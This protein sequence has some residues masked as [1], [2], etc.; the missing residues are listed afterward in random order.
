MIEV[1]AVSFS[2]D[3]KKVLE[4]IHISFEKNG[5]YGLLGPNGVGKSTLLKLLGNMLRPDEGGIFFDGKNIKDIPKKKLAQQIAYVP[6]Q[7][8]VQYA[9]SV[10]EI[11]EM[12]RHPYHERFGA[13]MPFEYELIR[14]A[15]DVT[16]LSEH[17]EHRIN[18][19]SSGEMQRVMIAR[20]LV[21]DTPIIILDEPIS[22]LDIH[23]QKEIILL[24]KKIAD[25]KN[26]I[27]ITVLH[28]MNVGLNYCDEI[29]LLHDNGVI[30]G[31]PEVVMTC[32]QIEAV[33][34]T[35][36]FKVNGEQG[37]YIHW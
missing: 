21:Q 12:G 19:L 16:G 22:H 3:K 34:K 23:Y 33:Y 18:E 6:Q 8:N 17:L 11:L 30:S 26:K 7:V 29:H 27:I 37:Q 10:K 35:S 31:K 9:F 25:E 24:L 14:F 2:Y 28:D 20:A 13:L 5:L 36:V 4:R 15:V 1:K 32:E